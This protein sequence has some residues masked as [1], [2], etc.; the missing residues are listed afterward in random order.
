MYLERKG[1]NALKSMYRKKQEDK[2]MRMTGICGEERGQIHCIKDPWGQGADAEKLG[3]WDG[4][5]WWNARKC[6]DML[7]KRM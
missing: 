6:K 7:Q 3:Y 4:F 1:H 5:S 2:C